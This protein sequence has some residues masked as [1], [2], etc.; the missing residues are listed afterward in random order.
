MEIMVVA[1]MLYGPDNNSFMY[2]DYPNCCIKC[3][4]TVR[5]SISPDFKLKRKQYDVSYTYDGYLIVSKKFKSFCEEKKYNN[6][7]FHNLANEPD[8]FFLEC[9]DI[10]SLDYDRRKVKFIDLC[11][12]CGRHAEVIGANPSYIE[13]NFEMKENTFYRSK[14]DFGSYNR[15]SPLI[16][17]GNEM[18][19]EML[20]MKFKG[21]YFKDV[22]D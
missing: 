21:L 20:K 19:E 16:I 4:Y 15:K 7:I 10:I 14:F 9:L 1:K 13:N 2:Y 18:A 6:Y 22:L 17:I 12:V 3:H 11:E 8:F 5:K